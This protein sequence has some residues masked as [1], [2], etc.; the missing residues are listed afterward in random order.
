MACGLEQYRAAVGRW[1]Q[2]QASLTCTVSGVQDPSVDFHLLG[3]LAILLFIGGVEANP[4]PASNADAAK[5]VP[6]KTKCGKCKSGVVNGIQCS[7][8][9]SWYH[10]GCQQLKKHDAPDGWVCKMCG[11]TGMRAKLQAQEEVIRKLRE[12]LRAAEEKLKD[13][14]EKNV[15][16]QHECE[17]RKN[18]AI[19]QQG[20]NR[21]YSGKVKVLGD[22][23]LRRS[24]G[25]CR[26]KGADV[27]YYPGCNVE[28]LSNVVKCATPDDSVKAVLVHVGTNV[29][30]NQLLCDIIKQ[31]VDLGSD[32]KAKYKNAKLIFSGVICRRDRLNSKTWNMNRGLLW[33]CEKVD[34]LFVDPNYW[35]SM[36]DICPDGVHL[37]PRGGWKL[38]RLHDSVIESCLRLES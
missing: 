19:T 34:A 9:S 26:R 37:N 35:L 5:E 10:F 30:R 3:V 36:A 16:L 2:R 15:R 22:S 11:E 4:G 29:Q 14:Q 28:Q 7:L 21:G 1:A 6:A 25:V 12:D 20:H 18:A 17:R 8:C 32:I 23:M 31:W 33:A 13:M 38:G 27:S 24:E